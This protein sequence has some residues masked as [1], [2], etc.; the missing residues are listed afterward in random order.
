MWKCR[1]LSSHALL[2]TLTPPTVVGV[3]NDIISKLVMSDQ[4]QLHGLLL[5]LSVIIGPDGSQT[6]LINMLSIKHVLEQLLE[7]RNIGKR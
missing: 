5:M 7:K 3:V 2:P 6:G 4:N 1:V